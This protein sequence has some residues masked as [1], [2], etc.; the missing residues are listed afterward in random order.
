MS[1]PGNRRWKP[2]KIK[3]FLTW[4]FRGVR[5]GDSQAVV[6]RLH[7]EA[8]CEA[9]SGRYLGGSSLQT[10]DE[11]GDLGRLSPSLPLRLNTEKTW[12][13]SSGSTHFGGRQKGGLML[14]EK[15]FVFIQTLSFFRVGS[16][17]EHVSLLAAIPLVAPFRECDCRT[18]S[19]WL[20]RSPKARAGPQ[21]KLHHHWG[22]PSPVILF[23]NCFPANR[24][25]FSL[26][27][28]LVFWKFQDS[29]FGLFSWS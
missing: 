1:C 3:K 15:G 14:G 5:P 27:H 17:R 19:D 23:G 24:K 10:S 12:F 25:D 26:C 18:S 22:L 4:I 2:E 20:F 13:N 7:Q 11:L 29:S 28:V 16:W 9:K 6:Y 8:H 21:S